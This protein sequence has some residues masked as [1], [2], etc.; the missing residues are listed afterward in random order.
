MHLPHYLLVQAL[1]LLVWL[2]LLPQDRPVLMIR[3][4]MRP[5]GLLSSRKNIDSSGDLP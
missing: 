1:V 3:I 4:P 2:V 5:F